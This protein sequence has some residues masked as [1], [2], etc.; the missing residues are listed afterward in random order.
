MWEGHSIQIVFPAYNEEENIRQAIEEFLA[1]GVV[2][3]VIVVD[4]NSTD[5]TKSEIL[6][7]A[8]KYVLETE[9]GYGAA[10]IRGLK[11]ATADY[12]ITCEPDGTFLAKDI[13]KVL[14]YV[15][16]FDVVFGTR[17]SKECIW[18]HAN[19]SWFLRLG[20]VIVAKMLE[21]LFNGPCLTDV[22]CTL[23]LI[24]R[25]Q[26]VR[27]QS[28]LRVK[29]SHFS[30][31][32]MLRVLTHGIRSVEIPVNYAPRKGTSKI[33]GDLV[34]TIKLGITMIL[35]ILKERIKKLF[36]LKAYR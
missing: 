24:K 21:Y 5:S 31:E 18:T 33:T 32:F 14:A 28:S 6:K 25:P 9:Q 34:K 23:K 19:M 4:N 11:E 26:L 17:T 36:R 13:F 8:A 20:N 3:E 12:V 29:G 22:G 2:D 1:T 15:D 35:F 30:P 7:T 16:D 27:I 10:L